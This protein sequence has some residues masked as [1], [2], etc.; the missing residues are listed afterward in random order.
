M[1]QSFF[2]LKMKET[3]AAW[4]LLESVLSIAGLCTT[5]TLAAVLG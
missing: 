2:N 4:S 5:L 1:V 3:F